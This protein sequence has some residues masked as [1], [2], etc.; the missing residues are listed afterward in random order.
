MHYYDVTASRLTLVHTSHWV[1]ISIL[2][3]GG[4]GEDENPQAEITLPLAGVMEGGAEIPLGGGL[5]AGSTG[6]GGMMTGGNTSGGSMGGEMVLGGNEPPAGG[7]MGGM[8]GG[9]T[10]GEMAGEMGGDPLPP[11]PRVNAGWIGGPCSEDVECAYDGGICLPDAGGYPRGMCTQSCDR[12]CPDMEGMP[13][14]FCIGGVLMGPG[15]C[16]QRCDYLAF[17]SVGCRPGY[18]CVLRGRYAE[19]GTTQQVCLPSDQVEDPGPTDPPPGSSDCLQRL[20]ALGVNYEYRGDQ[21]EVPASNPSLVCEVRDAVRVQNPINGVVYRYIESS[22]PSPLYGS[23]ELML[24]VYELSGLLREY[25]VVEVG[26]IGTYNCRVIAGTST[27]SRHGYGD[28]LDIGSLFTS[29]GDEL[30]VINHWEHDTT[31]FAT[32]RGRILYEIGQQM[33]QRGIFNMVLTP[34]Y[35]AAHDNHFHVDLTPG[36]NYHGK[37]DE[38]VHHCGNEH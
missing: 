27:L 18:S 32:E 28:A 33:H 22:S 21:T 15:A 30:S 4:C 2:L 25:N 14:T 20:S 19:P 31:N 36:A 34:N 24:A 6:E 10:G 17:P 23:C 11:D 29:D 1:V 5:G 37:M 26:H 16:V 13:V 35:N 12:F 38:E 7:M 3:L 9:M 8:T